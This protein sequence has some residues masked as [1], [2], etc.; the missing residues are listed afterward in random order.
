MFL[1]DTVGKLPLGSLST[2]FETKQASF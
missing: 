2:I 1:A